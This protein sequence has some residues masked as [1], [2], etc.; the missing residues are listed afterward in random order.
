MEY[1]T[2]ECSEAIDTKHTLLED[3]SEQFNDNPEHLPLTEIEI[4]DGV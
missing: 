4:L 3:E 2:V 1:R